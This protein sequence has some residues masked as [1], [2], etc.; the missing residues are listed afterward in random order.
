MITKF[1]QDAKVDDMERSE[2]ANFMR[3]RWKV[4]VY[5]EEEEFLL[6][7]GR[8]FFVAVTSSSDLK[9]MPSGDPLV[10]IKT[11]FADGDKL[12]AGIVESVIDGDL[13]ELA[14]FECPKISR[15]STKL[16]HKKGGA[17]KFTKR[18][19]SHS[20]YYLNRRDL[21]ITGFKHRE[22]RAIAKITIKTGAIDDVKVSYLFCKIGAL[23]YDR[24]QREDVIDERRMKDFIGNI[25]NAPLL[26]ED[27][28]K[29]I[30]ESME[31]VEEVSSKAK[32]IGGTAMD[33]VE[34]YIYPSKKG[35]AL[36]GMTVAKVDVSA[37]SLFA[38]LCLLDTYAKK[39]DHKDTKIRKGLRAKKHRAGGG[40]V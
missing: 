33:S 35:G 24:F 1:K 7:K 27:E 11:T 8:A 14:A 28:Q 30:G 9:V 2:Q 40:R 15:E 20:F 3:E 39:A 17:E 22:W 4:Q 25:D 13:E 16:F 21:N 34:K 37:V 5:S 32:R 29:L 23:L 19:N 10:T 36:V 18:V 38:Q 12:L 26:T 31:L 6:N